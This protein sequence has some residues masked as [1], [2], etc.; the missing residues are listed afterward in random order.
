MSFNEAGN[1]T[2]GASVCLRSQF[3]VAYD[4]A[5]MLISD[6]NGIPVLGCSSWLTFGKALNNYGVASLTD[7]SASVQTQVSSPLSGYVT[8]AQLQAAINTVTPPTETFDPV[9]AGEFFAFSFTG[10]LMCWLVSHLASFVLRPLR[11]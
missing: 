10:V 11:R 7:V 5:S 2:Y 8:Q 9:V 6:A 3:T 4:S 1:L